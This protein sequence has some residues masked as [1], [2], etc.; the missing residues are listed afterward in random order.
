[1]LKKLE[2]I[3]VSSCYY[4]REGIPSDIGSLSSLRFLNF[5][6]NKF[7]SLPP[8]IWGLSCL[9]TLEL[10]GKRL[11]LLP[12]LPWNLRTLEVACIP[13]HTGSVNSRGLHLIV[14]FEFVEVPS[15][16]G[17]L[18][19][20]ERL[21]FNSTN[22]RTLPQETFALPQLKWLDV[23]FCH[24]LQFLPTLPSS[25]VNLSLTF[26]PLLETLPDLSNLTNLQQLSFKN[27]IKLKEIPGIGKLESL[28]KL[29][30]YSCHKLANLDL[31]EQ[32][33]CLESLEMSGSEDLDEKPYLSN[34]KKLEIVSISD[35][36]ELNKIQGLGKLTS[37]KYLFLHRCTNLHWIEDLGALKSLVALDLSGCTL[38]N[39]HPVAPQ[40]PLDKQMSASFDQSVFEV[41][42]VPLWG[43]TSM[44]GRRPEMEDAVA[45]VP[46]FWKIPIQMLISDR[47]VDGMSWF[48]SHLSAHFFGVYDGYGGSQVASCCC[49]RVHFALTEELENVMA[50][51]NDGN[52][53][54]NCQEQWRTAFTNCFLK[55]DTEV[56]GQDDIGPVAPETVGSTA[57]VAIVCSSHIIV[58]NCGNS[59]AVLC[60]GKEPVALSVDHKP[61]RGDECAR[62]EAAGGKIIHWNGPRVF[63]VLAMSRS[64]GTYTVSEDILSPC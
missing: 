16:I 62:I 49:D 45:T 60:R 25:L 33:S 7:Q 12:E 42:C 31:L 35:C 3:D 55:V 13:V 11:Q 46:Q 63:G 6:N 50:S 53:K 19:S 2:M 5:Y 26:C 58:A 30:L 28:R 14:D 40:L 27:C 37:L 36:A 44:C 43:F 57:V 59:R 29:G 1:M 47:L 18:W 15:S 10:V 56:G 17:Q 39:Q 34:L 41:D 24:N 32:F 51:S 48:S 23:Q 20:L 22:I 52:I 64:I 38:L 8:S 4:L 54:G 21:F 9:Q 61:D